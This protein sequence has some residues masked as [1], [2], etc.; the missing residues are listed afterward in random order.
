LRA[1][2]AAE[3]AQLK[4][5]VQGIEVD[6]LLKVYEAYADHPESLTAGRQMITARDAVQWMK[7]A[8]KS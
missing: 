5:L 3:L 2:V 4:A 8:Y 7:A 6:D 1:R